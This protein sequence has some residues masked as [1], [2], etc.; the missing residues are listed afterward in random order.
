VNLWLA[1]AGVAG[2]GYVATAL[3]MFAQASGPSGATALDPLISLAAS[4]IGS[5]SVAGVL[6]LW[7]RSEQKDRR[8]A[9][10]AKDNVMVQMMQMFEADVAHKV[11][12]RL[13]LKGQDEALAKT[14][15][16][17]SRVER[18]LDGKSP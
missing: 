8:D 9:I 15:E 2:G 10:T 13:R 1:T 3:S 14:L 11:E 7:V 4:F 16:I 18:R 5:S 17:I 12:L 6:Y